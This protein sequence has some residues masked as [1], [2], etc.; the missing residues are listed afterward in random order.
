MK[1]LA[2]ECCDRIIVTALRDAGHDDVRY[3]CEESTGAD[4]KTILQQAYQDERIIVTEDKDFG[5]LVH[6]LHYETRGIVL[7]RISD[8]MRPAKARRVHERT[9]RHGDQLSDRFV[10]V[11]AHQTRFRPPLDT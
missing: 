2:D 3:L 5:E 9:R 6:R 1:L 8:T 11:E 7:I 4:D 10:V